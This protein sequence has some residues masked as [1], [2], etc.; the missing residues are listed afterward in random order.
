MLTGPTSESR[1]GH[2]VHMRL[3]RLV[4]DAPERWVPNPLTNPPMMPTATGS[5]TITTRVCTI[6]GSCSWSQTVDEIIAPLIPIP[7]TA[8]QNR[9]GHSV[10]ALTPDRAIAGA[11]LYPFGSFIGQA[12][13][14]ALDSGDWILNEDEPFYPAGPTPATAEF[15]GAI[16]GDDIWLAIG[17]PGYP[18]AAGQSGRVFVYGH[19]YDDTI[20]THDFECPGHPSCL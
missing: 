11:P 20:F 17:A 1:F 7:S 6:M 14:Y 4:V 19:D 5:L 8:A 16:S 18:D 2:S 15:G 9:L 10:H 12:R 3:G 13:H